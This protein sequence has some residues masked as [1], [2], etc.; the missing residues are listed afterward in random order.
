MLSFG[1]IFK[2]FSTKRNLLIK[3]VMFVG[4]LI[5][6]YW[7]IGKHDGAGMYSVR[8]DVNVSILSG[9]RFY[10]HIMLQEC[11]FL[12]QRFLKFILLGI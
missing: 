8:R 9:S 3:I 5:S 2:S 1:D 4:V 6:G 10:F 12:F 11:L 7:A